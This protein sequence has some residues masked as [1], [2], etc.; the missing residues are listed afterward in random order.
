[1]SNL[2]NFGRILS[3]ELDGVTTGDWALQ[4][5]NL[6][7]ELDIVLVPQLADLLQHAIVVLLENNLNKYL[8]SSQYFTHIRALV[9][10][11]SNTTYGNFFVAKF[12]QLVSVEAEN[13]GHV[14]PSRFRDEP[15]DG[16]V[17]ASLRLDLLDPG[18]PFCYPESVIPPKRL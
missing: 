11:D 6:F 10:E 17:Q 3:K 16:I 14:E 13:N 5:L 1:M 9:V 2:R 4:L 18:Y 8:L 15:T 7:L 12:S